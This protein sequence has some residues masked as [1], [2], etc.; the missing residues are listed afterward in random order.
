[1]KLSSK[2]TKL[3]VIFLGILV[4]LSLN[5]YRSEVKDFF[6]SISEPGQ[7]ILWKKGDNIS[8]FFEGLFKSKDLKRENEELRKY[9][10]ELLNEIV[11]LNELKKENKM[12]REAL[13]ISLQEDFELTLANLISKDVSG[14]FILINKG[15]KDGL[16]AGM[17]VITAQKVLLGKISDEV[18]E[19]FSRVILISNLES[20][21]PAEVQEG[22]ITGIIKG[23]GSSQVSLEKIPKDK[24]IKEGNIVITTSL[25]GIFPRELLIGKVN[26]IQKSD[27][28]PFQ[29]LGISPFFNIEELKTVFIITSF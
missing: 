5:F 17:P 25:G 7:K 26:K 21:F 1:M 15:S 3:L 19:N 6:Y 11:F 22:G 10:Q 13:G 9:N 18:S 20:S 27:I 16:S 14:D 24:E 29:K 28:E 12:L 23:E 4:I 8:D 2:K